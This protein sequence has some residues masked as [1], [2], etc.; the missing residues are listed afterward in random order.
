MCTV[1]THCRRVGNIFYGQRFAFSSDE[2]RCGVLWLQ[3]LICGQY[4]TLLQLLPCWKITFLSSF[5][6]FFVAGERNWLL[7]PSLAIVY[8]EFFTDCFFCVFNDLILPQWQ[9]VLLVI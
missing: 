5:S 2:V 7:W 3:L 8:S 1:I 6:R 9:V 4:H